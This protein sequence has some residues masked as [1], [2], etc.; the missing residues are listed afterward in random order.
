MDD[1]I[2][3]TLQLMDAPKE[4]LTIRSSYN[5]TGVSFTPK[6]LAEEIKK[7]FLILQSL[8]RRMILD[9]RLQIHGL[10]VLKILQLEQIGIGSLLLI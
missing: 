1:A 10:L 4:S 3:G 8:T 5:L 6:E 7:F 9:R 2:R